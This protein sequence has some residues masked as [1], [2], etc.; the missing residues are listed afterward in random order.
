MIGPEGGRDPE[1][2]PRLPEP[3][4]GWLVL[5]LAW[6]N[7]ERRYSDKT[8]RNYRQAVR[9]F[10]LWLRG[11]ERYT[12]ALGEMPHQMTRDWL[13][14]AGRGG[15]ERRTLH[16]HAS[17]VRGFFRFLLD[18]GLVNRNPM[19]GLVLPKLRKQ[20][21]RFLTEAQMTALLDTPMRLLVGGELKPFAAWRDQAMLEVFYGGGLRISEACALRWSQVDVAAGL[22][23]IR[24][25][26]GKDR[27]CPLGPVAMDCL[28]K[29]RRDFS[30]ATGPAD[31]V[32]L[33]D[34]R[35]P[36]GPRWIQRR[37]KYLLAR[38]GLPS[39]LSPHK[40]RHSFATHL[41][42]HGADLRLVQ[43]L[44]GH[45]SL[46]TTQVY[47]HVGVARLRTIHRQ[48]HPRG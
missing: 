34:Q 18:R 38:A 27:L 5:Y 22:A 29:W 46:S 7:N 19:T 13:I 21:P 39:D 9:D 2:G 8:V 41:L 24:G 42:D 10:L 12:G 44:L 33:T 16:L 47:T 31:L 45:S 25:K 1:A 14:E 15:L 37:L 11:P 48:A 20:L 17:A 43:T 26:G 40:L 30:P 23:R 35:K 36:V 4:A 32:L 3:E 28:E 6:L